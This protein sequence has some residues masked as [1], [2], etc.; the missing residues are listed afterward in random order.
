MLQ[1]V[2]NSRKVCDRRLLDI[3]DHVV[4]SSSVD[5]QQGACRPIPGG[6]LR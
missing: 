4:V 5:P 3:G 6:L 2:F 1:Q